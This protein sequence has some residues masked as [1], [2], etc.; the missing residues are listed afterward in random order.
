[1]S[2]QGVFKAGVFLFLIVNSLK[3]FQVVIITDFFFFWR[4]LTTSIIPC[5][6]RFWYS[7]RVTGICDLRTCLIFPQKVEA[8]VENRSHC[9]F[10][11]LHL[12]SLQHLLSS[13]LPL[14]PLPQTLAPAEQSSGSPRAFS[15]LFT[16]FYISLLS[17]L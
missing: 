17:F 10:C 11:H 13:L 14:I 5:F 16:F 12:C 1:M 6:L 3:L 7:P 8:E 2:A 15:V 9:L 4:R